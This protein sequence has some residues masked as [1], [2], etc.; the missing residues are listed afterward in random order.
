MSE[1]EENPAKRQKM[2]DEAVPKFLVL[3][4]H[5]TDD[6][7][8][9]CYALVSPKNSQVLEPH[10]VKTLLTLAA[11]IPASLVLADAQLS[12]AVTA[13]QLATLRNATT[14]NSFHAEIIYRLSRFRRVG[15]ALKC[16]G[17]NFADPEAAQERLVVLVCGGTREEATERFTRAVECFGSD[18]EVTS[19]TGLNP[20]VDV[21][22]LAKVYEVTEAELKLYGGNQLL[23]SVLT[24]MSTKVCIR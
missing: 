9:A 14:A 24:K 13:A 7:C 3:D 4:S 8:F 6:K 19:F 12:A 20:F 22:S 2:S 11:V 18:V 17:I 21:D 1:D 15:E 10:K 16:F 5:L 23:G